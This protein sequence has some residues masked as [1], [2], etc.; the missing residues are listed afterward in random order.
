MTESHVAAF[1]P[2]NWILYRFVDVSPAYRL[3]ILPHYVALAAATYGY[4]RRLGLTTGGSIAAALGLTLC[5]FQ[6]IHVIHG[7]FYTV[8]AYLP[9]CSLLADCYVRVSRHPHSALVSH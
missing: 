5:G 4:G 7:P 8:M 9:L 6:A 3:S 2:P 1:Y